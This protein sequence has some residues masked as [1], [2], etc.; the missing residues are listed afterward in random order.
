MN[1]AKVRAHAEPMPRYSSLLFA[2]PQALPSLLQI[3][4]THRHPIMKI[5]WSLNAGGELQNGTYGLRMRS[6]LG[7]DL[8]TLLDTTR[9]RVESWDIVV[10]NILMG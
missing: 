6:T 4:K 9:K 10:K 2:A 1:W 3:S 7:L 5:R 8:V